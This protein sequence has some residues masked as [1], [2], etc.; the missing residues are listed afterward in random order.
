MC[1]FFFFVVIFNIISLSLV[2]FFKRFF[3]RRTF[4]ACTCEKGY[5]LLNN[6]NSSSIFRSRNVYFCFI[7]W[8]WRF[9]RTL[10]H[11]HFCSVGFF[12]DWKFDDGKRE[13]K[14][15]VMYCRLF[16]FQFSFEIKVF[17]FDLAPLTAAS[18]RS[19]IHARNEVF[20]ENCV[21][22]TKYNAMIGNYILHR[23]N[24]D[25]NDVMGFFDGLCVE[26]YRMPWR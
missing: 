4:C 6:R 11:G 8:A 19:K 17:S 13:K 7:H 21:L 24:N 18:T 15:F 12:F 20:I 3:V 25:H 16:G 14:K 2:H 26:P 23:S 1:G 5:R 22:S 9:F 10:C